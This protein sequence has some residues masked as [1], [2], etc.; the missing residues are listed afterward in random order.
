M[1]ANYASD[2]E[3]ISKICKEL[4]QLYSIQTNNS[5]QKWAKNS[6]RLIQRI[7]RGSYQAYEKVLNVTNHQ[8]NTNQNQDEISPHKY[9]DSCYKV[10]QNQDNKYWRGY[11]EGGNS[12]T[13]LWKM[14]NDAVGMVNSGTVPQIIKNR[15]TI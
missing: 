2:K 10:K 3:L 13:I 7:H 9:Q 1:F 6:N 12:C 8:V 15:T 14:K 11:G 4:I 5:T